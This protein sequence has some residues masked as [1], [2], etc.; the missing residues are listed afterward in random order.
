[1]DNTTI[2]KMIE[3]LKI[4]ASPKNWGDSDWAEE[5]VFCQRGR[6]NNESFG[7]KLA[8]ECLDEI[9]KNVNEQNAP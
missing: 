9:N 8:Q 5:D 7:W 6:A 3:T 1:M 4:Y 2:E